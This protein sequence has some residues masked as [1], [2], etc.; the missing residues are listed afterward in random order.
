M[1]DFIGQMLIGVTEP[2]D[3]DCDGDEMILQ[4][5]KGKLHIRAKD[6]GEPGHCGCPYIHWE[7]A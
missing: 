2:W 1:K 4:F 7:E 6:A 3:D 5:E